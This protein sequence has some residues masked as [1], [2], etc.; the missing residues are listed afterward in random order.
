MSVADHFVNLS[1]WFV[2]VTNPEKNRL[3]FEYLKARKLYVISHSA[4][5][6]S[7]FHPGLR[8]RDTHKTKHTHTNIK[9]KMTEKE[10]LFYFI[11]LFK[12][13]RMKGAKVAVQTVVAAD[14]NPKP[15]AISA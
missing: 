12:R 13:H 9:R 7:S 3:P 5:D 15:P 6:N 8:L 10:S 1:P 2:H 14:S 11:H 4:V